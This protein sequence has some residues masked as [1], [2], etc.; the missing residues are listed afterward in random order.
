MGENIHTHTKMRPHA[1]CSVKLFTP[2]S[3][4]YISIVEKYAPY[5][6]KPHLGIRYV[7]S[8]MLLILC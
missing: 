5:V 7:G 3:E 1:C 8:F 6:F 4:Y 2:F